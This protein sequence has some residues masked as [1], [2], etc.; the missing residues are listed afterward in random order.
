M[1]RLD[2]NEADRRTVEPPLA[3]KPRG[4][5]RADARG[6][7]V[8]LL[9]TPGQASGETAVPAP[10]GGV[11]LAPDAVAERGDFTHAVIAR[12][13]VSRQRSLVERFINQ[14][15][16]FRLI[17]TRCDELAGSH[18]AAA[19]GSIRPWMRHYE[20]TAWPVQSIVAT[21][22]GRVSADEVDCTPRRPVADSAVYDP[23]ATANAYGC[24]DHRRLHQGPRAIDRPIAGLEV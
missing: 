23:L 6:L 9:P 22:A 13:G 8:G 15:K 16:H 17:A 18:L 12:F 1:A 5:A 7:P 24:S 3:D 4:S 20:S 19:F 10:S 2:P 11:R 21:L 14:F